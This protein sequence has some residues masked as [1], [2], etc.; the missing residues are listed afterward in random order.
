MQRE[1]QATPPAPY[2]SSPMQLFSRSHPPATTTA[3][4][5]TVF[6]ADDKRLLARDAVEMLM[7]KAE[8]CGCEL[9]RGDAKLI[10]ARMALRSY[11]PGDAL[12]FVDAEK[13]R[14]IMF[15]L[16]GEARLV[17]AAKDIRSDGASVFATG[18]VG[19]AL[20]LVD[21]FSTHSSKTIAVA[22]DALTVAVLSTR[23]IDELHEHSPQVGMVL[24]R[25][26]MTELAQLTQE[27][28][29]RT[30]AMSQVARSMMA[31]I[32]EEAPATQAQWADSEIPAATVPMPLEAQN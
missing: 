15:V 11:Q 27:Q 9:N 24:M 7:T 30:V 20:G 5:A 4:P 17:A 1:L 18:S 21:M 6:G 19:D 31:H 12:S 3:A 26:L 22:H 25:M 13:R 10:L 2:R 14:Q 8:R 16:H 29:R 28:I 23:A 32:D